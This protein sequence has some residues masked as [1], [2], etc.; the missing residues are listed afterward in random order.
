[1]KKRSF[2]GQTSKLCVSRTGGR[3]VIEVTTLWALVP[4]LGTVCV[5][6]IFLSSSYEYS[7]SNVILFLSFVRLI[8]HQ[9]HRYSAKL[10]HLCIFYHL[11]E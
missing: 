1:M 2:E 7:T 9:V 6:F 8:F 11:P 3:F 4:L 10:R 5:V